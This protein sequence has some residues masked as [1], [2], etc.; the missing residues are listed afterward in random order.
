MFKYYDYNP[1]FM[2]RPVSFFAMLFL[3]F[4][5]AIGFIF[6]VFDLRG[7]AFVFELGLLL[8]FMFILAFAMFFVYNY[9]HS[10][11]AIISAVLILLLLNVFV[12]FLLTRRLW[13]SYILTS[14]FAVAGLVIALVNVALLPSR[15]AVEPPDEKVYYY[16]YISKAEQKQKLGEAV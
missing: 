7:I 1:S 3:L 16:P 4:F 8:S 9:K 12:V 11:W 2:E 6:V 5:T 14:L 13:A 15:D 10:S